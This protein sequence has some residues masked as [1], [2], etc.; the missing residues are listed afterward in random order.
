MGW[1]GDGFCDDATNTESCDYDGGD[2]CGAD[3]ITFTCTQCLCLEGEG[4]GSEGT[5]TYPGC[6]C[7][8]IVITLKNGALAQQ[9][10][11]QGI[12]QRA[13][14]VNGK[15]SWISSN[16]AIWYGTDEYGTVFDDWM[17]GPLGELGGNTGGLA[18]TG[19]QGM[20]SCPYDVSMD[21][22]KYAIPNNG[23]TIA[24]AN[25]VSI[26]CLSGIPIKSFLRLMSG[27]F[28]IQS[29]LIGVK[30]RNCCRTLDFYLLFAI[31][32]GQIQSKLIYTLVTDG[33]AIL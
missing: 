7:Q 9:S 26:Q 2:C 1:V 20:S 25:D 32:M 5:T 10:L 8:T 19:N 17:I 13:E 15:T 21:A 16:M 6:V 4:G 22:W 11:K 28:H 18:S 12:Y 27:S 3:V 33:L 30:Y 14:K 31:W 23:W 29:V 24:D